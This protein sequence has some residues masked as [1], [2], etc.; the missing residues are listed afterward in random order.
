LLHLDLFIV[1]RDSKWDSPGA[2]FRGVVPGK[3]DRGV[4][5]KGNSRAPPFDYGRT[6]C[7]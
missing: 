1:G 3:E 4:S 2:C 7:L 6:A 5:K